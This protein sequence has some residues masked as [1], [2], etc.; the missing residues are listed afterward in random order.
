MCPLNRGVINERL[1]CAGQKHCVRQLVTG[2]NRSTTHGKNPT[3]SFFSQKVWFQNRRA[4]WRK[5]EKC[6]GHSSIMAEYG[7]YGAMV[8]HSLPLPP[9][10]TAGSA[11]WLLGMHKKAKGVE[12]GEDKKRDEGSP[13]TDD[14]LKSHSIA[15]LRQ[16]AKEH[17]QQQVQVAMIMFKKETDEDNSRE[18]EHDRNTPQNFQADPASFP[19]SPR[20]FGHGDVTE[21]SQRSAS[22]SVPSSPRYDG[23]PDM[24]DEEVCEQDP[25]TLDS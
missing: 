18:Y 6:W 15:A 1:H 10:L 13:D 2:E 21:T 3:F 25:E 5:K 14:N 20:F 16:K 17:L 22:V 8:R 12:S 11:P 23:S 4:K 7:L 24:Q 9:H 19:A